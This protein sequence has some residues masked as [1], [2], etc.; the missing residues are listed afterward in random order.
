VK[1]GDQ[2]VE[3]AAA[4]GIMPEMGARSGPQDHVGPPHVLRN[5]FALEVGAI[6]DVAGDARFAVADAALVDLRPHAVAADQRTVI[7]TFAVV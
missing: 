7:G 6:S 4:Q 3:L 5:V 2:I 1:N